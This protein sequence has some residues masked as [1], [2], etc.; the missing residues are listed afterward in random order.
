MVI[1]L[2]FRLR[3]YE[4]YYLQ[5]FLKDHSPSDVAW[6]GSIQAFAQFSATL[7]SGPI[8]YR[9]G[10]MVCSESYCK[11][12]GIL[13]EWLTLPTLLDNYLALLHPSSHRNDAY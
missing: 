12:F 2:T 7:I 11:Y 8:C 6:I 5:T 4:T 3:V 13:K 1:R 9:H 10:P